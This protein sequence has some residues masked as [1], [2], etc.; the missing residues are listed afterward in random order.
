MVTKQIKYR[1][2][3]K[4]DMNEMIKDMN[5]D[6]INLISENLEELLLEFRS[7]VSKSI[8]T[9]APMKLSKIPFRDSRPW[10]NTEQQALKRSV[11]YRERVWHRYKQDDQWHAYGEYCNKYT[12]SLTITRMKYTL[13]EITKFKGNTKHLHKLIA[14]LT[15]SKVVN[16]LPEGLSHEDLAEHFA[17]FFIEKIENI[18]HKLNN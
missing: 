12:K 9:R 5:L 16:P 3:K 4:A 2:F 18:R 14:E 7:C 6:S 17:N 10:Y 1:D 11:R 13:I 15:A 8:E